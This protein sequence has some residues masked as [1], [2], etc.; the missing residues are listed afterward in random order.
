M[1]GRGLVQAVH[2]IVSLDPG[3]YEALGT[4]LR[5]TLSALLW[6]ALAGFP[7]GILLAFAHFRAK[8]GIMNVMYTFMGFPPVVA[9]LL[10]YLLLSRSGPLG[11]LELLYTP[12]AMIIAQILLAL[13]VIIGTHRA[14]ASQC[15]QGGR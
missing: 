3:T 4:S 6:S 10:V 11:P 15:R 2:L 8:Q 12:T 5:V 7:L 13:P 9:G 1:I 14:G